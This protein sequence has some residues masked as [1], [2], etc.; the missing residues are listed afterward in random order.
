[1]TEAR[2]DLI[3]LGVGM[4]AVSA[5]KK[6]AAAGWSVAVVDPLPYGGT[7][8]LRG[9]DPKKML[10]R[11]A[12]IID[13]ARLMQG[14]GIEPGGL[15]IDWAD[16]VAF[17]R[18]FTEKMPDK[19]EGGLDDDG[20]STFH[21]QARFIDEQSID[22]DGDQRLAGNHILIATGAKPR[23]LDVPG[24][25]HLIDS[26]Q[27]MELEELP[28]RI[29]FVGG[30]YVSFE[31]AH[32]AARAGSEVTI[33]DRGA[34]PLKGFD[35]D[36][37][38]KLVVRSEKAGI[39]LRRTTELRAICSSSKGYQVEV[40]LDGQAETLSADLVVHGAGRVAAIDDLDLAAAGVEAGKSGVAVNEYLQSR[41]NAKVYAAGDA[42]D[43]EGAPLTPVAVFEGKVAAANMI[44]G[45][46]ATP[47]YAGVPSVVFTIPELARVGMLEEEARNAGHDIRIASNDTSNWYSNLRVGEHCA[48]TKV[49]IDTETDEILGAHLLGLE[50]AEIIN[51]FGLAIRLGLT[52][53]ELKKM[54]AA[55]PSVGSDLGS[56]L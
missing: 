48:A 36:L 24:A 21:G 49:I 27:F 30:G 6:C 41:S 14:K 18:S 37:V 53:G 23:P 47:D 34:R 15:T 55:Y 28:R 3:V 20:I 9:C 32:I 38:E 46:T 44:K 54:V 19:I 45:N 10:R 43:T 26:T 4:A 11:G 35:A 7:C 29:V 40:D 17:K 39:V 22:I 33:L 51:F 31:F 42:A 5:A 13:A 12:E 25:E 16:L 56:M 52:V 8:A 1:M 2:Y 50:Y